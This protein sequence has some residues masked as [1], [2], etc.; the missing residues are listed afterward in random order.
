[1]AMAADP[2]DDILSLEEK[3]YDEGF[4]L[5]KADGEK[6]GRIEGRVFGLE[7]GFEKYVES[8]RLHGRSLVWISRSLHINNTMTNGM[9]VASKNEEKLPLPTPSSSGVDLCLPGLSTNARI[10]KHLKI[11]YALT[12]PATLS[13]E[14]SEDAVSDFDDRL[15]RAVG[16]VKMIERIVGEEVLPRSS[17][18]PADG[19]TNNRQNTSNEAEASIE[20]VSILK[21]RH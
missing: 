11:L 1:M 17:G 3:F 5:G 16:R 10:E 19:A 21:A 9:T 20:D 15:K 2:F 14:N 6:A 12:E 18:K 13:T 4:Q 8:G 7:K